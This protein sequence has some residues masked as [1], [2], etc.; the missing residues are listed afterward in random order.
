M[1]T[2]PSFLGEEASVAQDLRG[3]SPTPVRRLVALTRDDALIR[4]LEELTASGLDVCVVSDAG[5]LSEEL[6]D[7]IGSTALIDAEAATTPLAEFVDALTTQFPTL[8][9]LAAGHSAEQ[10]LLAT[11]IA[12]G[13]VYRFV[14]KP[15]S[16]QRLKLM[17]DAASRPADPQRVTV[18]QTIETLPDPEIV[19]RPRPDRPIDEPFASRKLPLILAGIAVAVAGGIWLLWPD[20]TAPKSGT[21]APSAAA[22]KDSPAAAALRN[23]DQA[24]A[25]GRYAA[26]DGSSA[27]ELYR[28]A[29]KLDPQN[30]RAR[31][32]FDRSIEMGLRSAEQA[33]VAERIDEAAGAAETL[34]LLAPENSRLAFLKSQI[35]KES[36]RINASASQ[37]AAFEARQQ[38]IRDSLALMDESLQRGALIEPARDNALV[39]FR[40][41]ESVGPGDAAVRNARDALL[42]AL[43]NAADAELVAARGPAARSYIDAAATINSGAPGLDPLRRRLDQLN[44]QPAATAPAAVPASPPAAAP[45]LAAPSPPAQSAPPP[46]APPA[47]EPSAD[48]AVVAAGTLQR[49]SAVEPEYPRYALQRLISGWVE[50]EFTVNTEGRVQDIRV[51]DA[52][53]A[54]VFNAAAIA[55]VR[56]WR[57]APVMRGG[58]A[59]PQ[60]AQ[61]RIRF[62]ASDR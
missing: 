53:P 2:Y 22:Q 43:L 40:A 49:I 41:A 27:A 37:R 35:D 11:R 9:V 7:N 20:S 62:T 15:A 26:A 29:L 56:R 33:L 45:A 59:V 16:A 42:A 23:A 30:E 39:H 12:S 47:A 57:Y 4:S 28:D 52:E 24:F 5:S 10:N 14:H 38:Q 1:N 32:G 60:R 36:A 25:A 44:A 48:S 21:A 51:L 19:P 6:L 46:V 18:T 8:R 58:V 54:D 61:Q 17:V 31:S 50:L 55:A 3:K 13:R 34:R